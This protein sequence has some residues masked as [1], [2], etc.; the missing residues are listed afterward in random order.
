ML[1][2][3]ARNWKAEPFSQPEVFADAH[4]PVVDSRAAY[5]VATAVAELPGK[6]L[7]ETRRVEPFS[8]ALVESVAAPDGNRVPG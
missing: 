8:D 6:R 1:N 3:S 2:A 4:I 7:G 5:H